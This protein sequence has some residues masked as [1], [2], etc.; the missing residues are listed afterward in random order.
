MD[1][2]I[3]FGRD[4]MPVVRRAVFDSLVANAFAA[5]DPAHDRAGFVE[6]NR[7]VAELIGP[8]RKVPKLH[9]ENT[10]HLESIPELASNLRRQ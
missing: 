9:R 8:A 5:C 4:N 6:V 7:E 1:D 10:A 3:G 2:T